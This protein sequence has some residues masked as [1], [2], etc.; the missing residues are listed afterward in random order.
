MFEDR[1]ISVL[2][3]NL[4]TVLAEK[5]SACVSL[6]T[7]N[8]RMK[9]YYDI[10]ILTKTHGGDISHS[11]FAEALNRTSTQRHIDIS[12]STRIIAE[13][14]GD[15]E[16]QRLWKRYQADNKYADGIAFPDTVAALRTL[17]EWGGLADIGRD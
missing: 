9:D 14:G 12:D 6:G 7:A 11:L 5:F 17:A 2:A 1:S 15:A 4:E 16:M 3:Y 10:F 8:T 13:V